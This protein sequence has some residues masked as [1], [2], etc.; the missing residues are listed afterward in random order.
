M[1]WACGNNWQR[2]GGPEPVEAFK[3]LPERHRDA[4]FLTVGESPDIDVPRCEI[5]GRVPS[6]AV[7]AYYRRSAISCMPTHIEPFGIVFL[8]AIVHGV[9]VAAP[10]EGAM[11]DYIED[12]KTGALFKPGDVDD[13]VRALTWFLDNPVE[14]RAIAER[15]FYAV[16]GKYDWNAVGRNLRAE[17]VPESVEK[18]G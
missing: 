16:R 7:A 5:V 12:K 1:C 14:R 15:A 4:R 6:V 13:I 11:V 10:Q 2:K 9:A 18:V 3:R 17:I 8:E